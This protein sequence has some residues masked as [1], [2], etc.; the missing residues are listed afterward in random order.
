ML[1][2][3]QP[4]FG[5]F[6]A[7]LN[8]FGI[9]IEKRR[10]ETPVNKSNQLGSRLGICNHNK[11]S[12]NSGLVPISLS[13]PLPLNICPQGVGSCGERGPGRLL[14]QGKSS[15]VA[16]QQRDIKLKFARHLKLQKKIYIVWMI[17][18]KPEPRLTSIFVYTFILENIYRFNNEDLL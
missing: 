9:M 15:C 17:I 2:N 7:N 1:G 11:T 3:W 4:G 10:M 8:A 12:C 16:R 6:W 13:M 5:V 18:E 14:G